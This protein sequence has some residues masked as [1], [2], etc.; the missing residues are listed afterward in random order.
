MNRDLLFS[1]CIVRIHH[2]KLCFLSE[3][4]GFNNLITQF[5]DFIGGLNRFR[6]FTPSLSGKFDCF[7]NILCGS[8]LICICQAVPFLH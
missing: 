8:S 2:R 3:L 5:N 4:I 7:L 6:S 1:G